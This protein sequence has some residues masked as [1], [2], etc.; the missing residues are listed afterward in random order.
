MES[1][2]GRYECVASNSIGVTYSSPAM[3]YIKG[4]LCT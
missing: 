1:D 2:R 3:L 4:E